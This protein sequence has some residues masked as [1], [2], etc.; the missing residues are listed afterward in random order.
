VRQ[1]SIL[2]VLNKIAQMDG[3]IPTGRL[4]ADPTNAGRKPTL[5][6]ADENPPNAGS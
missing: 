5:L 6:M 1:V 3:F 4:E 2:P